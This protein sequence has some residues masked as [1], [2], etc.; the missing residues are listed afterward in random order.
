MRNTSR[1]LN[2]AGGRFRARI[3]IAASVL[4]VASSAHAAWTVERTARGFA[5]A[6]DGAGHVPVFETLGDGQPARLATR[7]GFLRFSKPCGR[8]LVRAQLTTRPGAA[9]V[10]DE[11]TVHRASF[12]GVSLGRGAFERF[13]WRALPA[14]DEA[15]TLEIEL[16]PPAATCAVRV[17]LPGATL[18][19][20]RAQLDAITPS[21]LRPADLLPSTL[22]LLPE[23]RAEAEGTTLVHGGD[24][25]TLRWA[26]GPEFVFDVPAETRELVLAAERV[27]L[28]AL[29]AAS[30]PLV[31]GALLLLRERLR[32]LLAA[33]NPDVA[34]IK[35]FSDDLRRLLGPLSHG[36]DPLD[37]IE[38]SVRLGLV[39]PVDGRAQELALYFPPLP[40]AA[41]RRYPLIVALHGLD[42]RAMNFLRA[43]L[44]EHATGLEGVARERLPQRKE[45]LDAFVLAPAAHG[46]AMYR[47]IGERAVLAAI[48]A[49]V[50]R[51][52]IDRDRVTI[53]GA[54]MGGTGAAAIA[55]RHPDGFAAAMP[56]CGY[57]SYFVRRDLAGLTLHPWES[58][59]AQQR[60]PALQAAN[61]VGLPLR[62]VHGTQDYPVDNSK[63]LVDAYK[64]LGQSVVFDTPAA[65][66]DVWTWTFGEGRGI[67]WL[68][69]Q[70][71]G[72]RPHAHY[73]GNDLSSAKTHAFRIEEALEAP[74]WFELDAREE[75]GRTRVVTKGVERLSVDTALLPTAHRE[76]VVDGT[77][78]ALE[79]KRGLLA[80][81]R[82]GGRWQRAKGAPPPRPIARFRD[83]F[84][85][86]VLVAVGESPTA[87]L[88]AES[89]VPHRPFVDVVHP[90]VDL[91][92]TPTLPAD[93]MVLVV[94][95]ATDPRVQ[96]LLERHGIAFREGSLRL[97]GRTIAQRDL[98]LTL[99]LPGQNLAFVTAH[100]DHAL[101]HALAL[102]DLLPT[103]VVAD[104][105]VN[106]DAHPV[107]AG[108]RRYVLA[109][110]ASQLLRARPGASHTEDAA[111]SRGEL[112]RDA[113]S[114][115]S[116]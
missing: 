44:G 35:V 28:D 115:A 19:V 111:R 69:A 43:A 101:V 41:A 113:A 103:L 54:S 62:V 78:L 50:A 42:G 45:P 85:G 66:H 25:S 83:L 21:E 68:L 8:V 89:F 32:E 106:A 40:R 74:S 61:G 29:P 34:S 97:R 12:G 94:G 108:H 96:A 100:D 58:S 67:E 116:R 18:H 2:E 33:P 105:G 72:P 86:A 90:M 5:L 13:S 112:T 16:E 64:R 48:D 109:G 55:L 104:A 57:Q 38:G 110:E 88:V 15:R 52:P 76:V 53:T 23:L 14:A 92:S 71:R 17:R 102:P 91:A 82:R 114:D 87:R 3:S 51:L 31:G 37:T 10:V 65:G 20:D 39:A 73:E 9:L 6:S 81:E 60:S 107:V 47:G 63:V 22:T 77:R 56:L 99:V 30:R 98:A 84:Q 46:N 59:G 4:L 79:K 49:V 1:I 27:K 26:A 36:R 7:D 80:L 11:A 24:R 93:R 95:A 70:R 75:K